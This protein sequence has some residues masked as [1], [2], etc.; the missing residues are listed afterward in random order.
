MLTQCFSKNTIA[1]GSSYQAKSL[2]LAAN[3]LLMSEYR[4]VVLYDVD[5]LV[6]YDAKLVLNSV[7]TFL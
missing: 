7:V 2:C 5:R 3:M 4:K 1:T 6:D